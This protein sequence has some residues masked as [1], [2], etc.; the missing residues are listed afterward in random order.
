VGANDGQFT[1]MSLDAIG[2]FKVQTSVF[3][4]EL[5]RNRAS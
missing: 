3:N 4:A 1:Q 2:E 5:G